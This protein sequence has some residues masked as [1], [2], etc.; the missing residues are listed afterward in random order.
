MKNE[1]SED[2]TRHG[3]RRRIHVPRHGRESSP[4]TPSRKRRRKTCR[5]YPRRGEQ[6]FADS[7]NSCRSPTGGGD[8]ARRCDSCS[9]LPLSAAAQTASSSLA[10]SPSSQ[11]SQ[12]TWK[13][14]NC[15]EKFPARLQI[16]TPEFAADFFC[17]E[18]IYDRG[19]DFFT[20]FS[21]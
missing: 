17:L 7:R 11:T 20:F 5:Q 12:R 3:N 6:G 13:K 15:H 4:Q 1:S 9:C 16:P 18:K 2:R 19:G 10:P 8:N 14:I 21:P